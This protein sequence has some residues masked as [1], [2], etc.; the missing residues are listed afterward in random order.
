[1][2]EYVR[3]VCRGHVIDGQIRAIDSELLATEDGL[4]RYER[5]SG[6]A[7]KTAGVIKAL[8]TS[9]RLTH[10]AVYSTKAAALSEKPKGKLWQREDLDERKAA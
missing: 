7:T 10:A 3:H 8:A 4:R 9:M 6:I 1:M 2:V 5:L